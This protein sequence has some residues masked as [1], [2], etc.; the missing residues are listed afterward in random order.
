MAAFRR[1]TPPN[2][3]ILLD[4]LTAF[5]LDRLRGYYADQGFQKTQFES[6]L[7][8]QPASSQISSPLVRL[9]RISSSAGGNW[10]VANILRKHA[11]KVEAPA[12][13]RSVDLAHFKA[14]AERELADDLEL[15][16]RDTA[17]AL[18]S[19]DY[20]SVLERL[21]QL[22]LPVD[23]F[24]DGVLVNAEI[25]AS[26]CQSPRPARSIECAV[27]RYCRYHMALIQQ[28]RS[29]ICNRSGGFRGLAFGSRGLMAALNSR[30]KSIP[31][32]CQGAPVNAR[33]T[34]ADYF[35]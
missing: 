27:R 5:V 8:L 1:C 35:I 21:S 32:V 29:A 31:K 19:V 18:A 20:P 10:R 22:Q 12:I 7:A 25:P 14:D 16:Q 33:A 3:A 23:T 6:V 4:E 17:D 15:D 24:R 28:K 13:G 26:A 9:R 11:E 2:I 30:G 34:G